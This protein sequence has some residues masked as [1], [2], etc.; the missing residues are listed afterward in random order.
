M[1]IIWPK[2]IA[3]SR[4]CLIVAQATVSTPVDIEW[5]GGITYSNVQRAVTSLLGH[6]F[7]HMP[8][9]STKSIDQN[10]GLALFKVLTEVR[11]T[12]TVIRVGQLIQ[13][14]AQFLPTMSPRTEL[15]WMRVARPF[16]QMLHTAVRLRQNDCHH[17]RSY[18]R[19]RP[20]CSKC[21][22][23]PNARFSSFCM[24]GCLASWVLRQVAT[25]PL[26]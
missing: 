15:L 2:N 4:P 6:S 24:L 3:H 17:H 19:C 12:A 5:I 26:A 1:P 13:H 8:L 23:Q 14:P 20:L 10:D 25:R 16:A 21:L 22:C 9:S 7:T 11:L 18:D